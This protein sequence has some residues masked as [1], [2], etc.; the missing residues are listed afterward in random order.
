LT[1]SERPATVTAKPLLHARAGGRFRS[2]PLML[3]VSIF[4]FEGAGLLLSLERSLHSSGRFVKLFGMAMAGVAAFY[5]C[6]GYLG[7][8]TFGDTIEEIITNNLAKQTSGA[9]LANVVKVSHSV[10]LSYSRSSNSMNICMVAVLYFPPFLY[11]SQACLCFS[12]GLSYPMALMPVFQMLDKNVDLMSAPLADS[13]PPTSVKRHAWLMRLVVVLFTSSIIV[14]GKTYP[15]VFVGNP[16]VFS[17]GRSSVL[18]FGRFAGQKQKI[19][20][21]FTSVWPEKAWPLFSIWPAKILA[22]I[23]SNYKI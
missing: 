20:P 22:L 11:S 18:P 10:F 19:W 8:I 2:L 5:V 1:A 14:A 21:F 7:V 16:V 17:F 23:N 15:R 4:S 9:S 12:I 6:F 3:S 13:A